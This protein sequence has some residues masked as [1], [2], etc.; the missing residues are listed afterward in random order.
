MAALFGDE[1]DFRRDFARIDMGRAAEMAALVFSYLRRAN[2][3]AGL[4]GMVAGVA[5]GSAD[6]PEGE[7]RE[8]RGPLRGG[9]APRRAAIGLSAGVRRNLGQIYERWDGTRPAARAERRGDRARGARRVVRAGRDRAARCV[10]RGGGAR[11]ARSA[12]RQRLRPASGRPLPE[13]RGRTDRRARRRLM[14]RGAGARTRTARADVGSRVRRG[15]PRDGG[16]RRPEVA[17]F[18]RPFARGCRRLPQRPR[19][20]AACPRPTRPIL[21]APA[22]CTTSGR[23][24]CRRASG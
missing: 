2:A 23:S 15:V 3:G 24:R 20:A 6:Q 11:E 18:G 10:R 9:R 16:F 14:G 21:P 1:I 8:H 19:A 5:R 22:C 17:L 12:R 4:F 7:R 13:A